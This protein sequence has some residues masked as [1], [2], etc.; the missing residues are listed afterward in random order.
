MNKLKLILV[1]DEVLIR[2]LIRMKMDSERLNIEIVGEYSDA[3]SAL[4]ELEELQPDIIVS[5]IC[6]PEIDGIHFS[7]QCS[8]ML[9]GVKVIIITGYDDFDYARRS[10]KAGVHDFL[11][12]PVQTEELNTALEK[13]IQ[14]IL[15]ERELEARQKQLQEEWKKSQVLL[16]D[17]YLKN[18]LIHDVENEEIEKNLKNYGVDTECCRTYGLS[19]GVL[20]IFESVNNPEILGQVKNEVKSFFQGEKYVYT[21]IDFW[22]RLSVVYCGEFPSFEE[23]FQLLTQYLTQK[24]HYQLEYGVSKKVYNWE[25]LS[26]AYAS[27]LQDMHCKHGDVKEE[28][29][30]SQEIRKNVTGLESVLEYIRLGKAEDAMLAWES[31]WQN[32]DQKE[33]LPKEE[34]NY[35]IQCLM[36]DAGERTEEI[37]NWV[38]GRLDLCRSNSDIK[39]SM[40]YLIS[41]LLMER[42]YTPESEKGKMMRKILV[43][44]QENIQNPKLSVNVL[45]E[46]FSVSSSYLNRLFKACMGKTY[47]EYVSDLRYCRMLDYMNDEPDMRDRQM[48]ER[49]GLTDAHY[50]SIWFRKMSGYSVTEYRKLKKYKDI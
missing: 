37:E 21:I 12:K 14:S 24:W 6:M 47:S 11:M 48:G 3:K 50:L 23:Y 46:E 33:F 17:T 9:P 49:I 8:K 15:Q 25:E 34:V 36:K 39:K 44:L 31:I 41:V 10:L 42:I 5:D 38:R 45:T 22:G 40:Q 16:R 27:A 30:R 2:K 43:Y 35:Q 20:A 19:V 4:E 28:L 29:K 32:V 26:V 7:E 1:D 18:L 13:V